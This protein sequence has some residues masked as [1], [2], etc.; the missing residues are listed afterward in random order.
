LRF[1]VCYFYNS[2]GN[3]KQDQPKGKIDSFQ[4]H[5][6]DNSH[7]IRGKESVPGISESQKKQLY[8]WVTGLHIQ[9]EK[10]MKIEELPYF[11]ENGIF[12]CDLI[13]R[14]EGV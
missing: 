8:E 12:L 5:Y 14:L 3:H 9:G 2:R 6:D 13:N 11:F 4:Q 10:K 1:Q 7:I